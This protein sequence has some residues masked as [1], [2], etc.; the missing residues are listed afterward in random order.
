MANVFFKQGT[1]AQYQALETKRADTLYWLLDVKK[2]YKGDVLFGNGNAIDNISLAD[3]SLVITS[4]GT[5]RTI[6][7]QL[8]SAEGNQIQLA[9]DG[10]F[11]PAP[12]EV[13]IPEYEIERQDLADDGYSATYL[14]KRTLGGTSTYEGD[15]INIPKDLVVESGTVE[16]VTV[17]GEPYAGAHV[18]DKY[19][20]L[21]LANAD[22]SHI[23]IPVND[24]VD[25][26]TAGSGIAI[27]NN[28]ISV[29]NKVDHEIT[30]ANGRALIFNEVDGGGAK[31]EHAD[32]TESFIGVNDGGQSGLAAQIYA[33]R[34]VDGKRQ[35]AKLDVTNGGM[36]YTVGS[37]PFAQRAVAANEIATK[38][39]IAA[40]ALVWT[41]I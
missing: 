40:A 5:S 2:L 37:Q 31:F 30:S 1:L 17:E 15:K 16:T 41:D 29:V 8:S 26:Y 33:D 39:D 28:V 14:L 9:E 6:G 12:A 19:I 20:D 34:L 21:V 36:Y 32:G 11:V 4:E 7:V 3:G 27:N 38:G 13:L 18:G 35:G 24:L 25:T 10:L 22:S 23:Y